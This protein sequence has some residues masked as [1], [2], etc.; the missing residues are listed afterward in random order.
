M[1]I[2]VTDL[3][4]FL[5]K[6]VSSTA[7]QNGG[8]MADTPIS[9]TAKNNGYPDVSSYVREV[10]SEVAGRRW[11]KVFLANRNA[12][13]LKGQYPMVLLDRPTQYGDYA[14]FV[15]ADHDNFES[16]LTGS[17]P[18]YGAALLAQDALSGAGTIQVT[19]EDAFLAAMLASG[20]EILISSRAN[21]EN[22]TSTV[23]IEEKRSISGAP[24]VSG[25]TATI[26]LDKALTADF[27]VSAGARIST[28]YR[29]AADVAPMVTDWAESGT[30]SF[31]EVNAPLRLDN[32]GTIRQDWTMTYQG[33]TSFVLA[34]DTLGALGT[35]STATDAAP[36]NSVNGKPLLTI[37]K[38]GHGSAHV[39]GDIVTF[40]TL[41]AAIP[42]FVN[43]VI[44]PDT[45]KYGLTDIAICWS[46]ESPG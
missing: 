9:L 12:E 14:Y 31:D 34:G 11:R 41:P 37:P 2:L 29:P 16:G 1:S 15:P 3:Q 10:G 22:T 4:A 43:N 5:S 6:G 25:L 30:G 32:T 17:E 45:T 40:K 7:A 18:I 26:T 33:A 44:P 35:F 21:F 19:L 42:V 28:V 39:S 24:V 38:E 13:N 23:G 36:L 27:L 8:R 20:R 46:M